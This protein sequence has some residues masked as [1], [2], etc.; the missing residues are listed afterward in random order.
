V[1]GSD[2][3]VEAGA[4]GEGATAGGATVQ[5]QV[6]VHCPAVEACELYLLIVKTKLKSITQLRCASRQ[7]VSEAQ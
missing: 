3:S 1:G 7:D 6:F 2:V 5:L 4:L